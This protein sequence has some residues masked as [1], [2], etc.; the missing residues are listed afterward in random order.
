L[1]KDT[2]NLGFKFRE[3]HGQH[4]TARM[5]DQIEAGGKKIGVAA[6]SLA[7][8]PLDAVALVGLA[9]NFAHR[10]SH[11][12]WG[13]SICRGAA[14]RLRR[15]EP[16]HGCGLPFAAR[17]IGAEKVRVPAQARTGERL[18]PASFGK[19]THEKGSTMKSRKQRTA[20][21]DEER[22]TFQCDKDRAG[23]SVAVAGTDGDTLAADRA[24]AAEH[25]GAGFGL[26]ARA[27][28][29]FFGAAAAV[30]LKSTLGHRDPLLF[31]KENL[32]VSSTF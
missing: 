27:K 7:H 23:R 2:H 9:H 28:A 3:F 31:P 12:R 6:E 30:G 4:T 32:R 22:G 15:K 18:A 17:S 26:H 19:G 13:Q 25:G 29:V 16:A 21:I 8:A 20:E 1:L 14:G 11:T 24:T 5:K 10:E